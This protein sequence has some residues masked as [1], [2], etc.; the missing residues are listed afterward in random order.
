VRHRTRR[1]GAAPLTTN[2]GAYRILPQI[3]LTATAAAPSAIAIISGNN[4]S[5]APGA[6]LLQQLVGEVRGASGG[7]L[8]GIQVQWDVVDPTKATL[9]D[10]VSVSDANG[11]VSTR[12]TLGNTPGQ[13]KSVCALARP[14]PFST[15]R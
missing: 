1:I 11:R 7:P 14:A 12:V 8:N 10:T 2:V 15:Q 3:N 9:R 13:S 5:G 6:V 4:Q